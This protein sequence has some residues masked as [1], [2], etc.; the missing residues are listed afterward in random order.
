M[1]KTQTTQSPKILEVP[2]TSINHS[3][4]TN[5]QSVK[6]LVISKVWAREVVDALNTLYQINKTVFS[7]LGSCQ[8]SKP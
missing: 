2:R 5:P 1:R 4:R 6:I 7:I 3:Q 8:S